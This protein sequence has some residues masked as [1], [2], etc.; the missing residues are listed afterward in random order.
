M[1]NHVEELIPV[2]D[3]FPD[4]L[5]P[6]AWTVPL[7]R[8]HVDLVQEAPPPVFKEP[9]II[10]KCRRVDENLYFSQ[11]ETTHYSLAQKPDVLLAWANGT[12]I[13]VRAMLENEPTLHY[14]DQDHL[15]ERLP[16]FCFAGYSGSAHGTALTLAY[17]Q[18]YGHEFGIMYVRKESETKDTHGCEIERAL[19]R[20][21]CRPS[22]LVF[23]DEQ[24]SSGDTRS[25]VLRKARAKLKEGNIYKVD[26]KHYIQCLNRATE[27]LDLR[28]L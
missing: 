16:I 8:T 14:G 17:H 21:T 4:T 27:I 18:K 15:T 23:V 19:D 9:S 7:F 13:N 6:P 24:V 5:P 2:N 12:A 3:I 10:Q 26:T 11:F 28:D 1:T 22:I 20:V 25:R